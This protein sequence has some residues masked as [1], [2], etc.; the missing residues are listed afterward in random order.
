[1]TAI[2]FRLI[3]ARYDIRVDCSYPS[4]YYI[5]IL[6]LGCVG[7]LIYLTSFQSTIYSLLY[8]SPNNN[9]EP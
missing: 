2:L 7:K 8:I 6:K 9:I 5:I 3:I 4:H 1:M